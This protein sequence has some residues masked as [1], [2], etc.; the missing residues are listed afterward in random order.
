[1]NYLIPT[2]YQLAVIVIVMSVLSAGYITWTWSPILSQFGSDNAFYLIMAKFLS[3][4]SMSTP[5]IKYLSIHN[6][7]PPFFPLTLAMF[8]GGESIQIAHL[9]TTLYLLVVFLLFMAWMRLEG[10]SYWIA[11]L[12]TCIFALLPGTYMQALDIISENLYLLLSMLAMI[13]VTAAEKQN[14]DRLLYYGAVIIDLAYLTRS[15][16]ITLIAAF[17]LYLSVSKHPG[18]WRYIGVVVLPVVLWQLISEYRG[19]VYSHFFTDFYSTSAFQVFLKQVVFEAGAL[20]DGWKVNINHGFGS[21]F[22][23]GAVA[24]VCCLGL[25]YR[26]YKKKFDAIYL[27]IYFALI[28]VWPYPEEAARF[29]YVVLPITL[30]QGWYILSVLASYVP[31]KRYRDILPV[32]YCLALVITALPDL[33][34]AVQ[35]YN[36]QPAPGFAN[37]KHH[38]DWYASDNNEATKRLVVKRALY[39]D[40]KNVG[41]YVPASGCVFSIKPGLVGLLSG[42]ISIAPPVSKTDDELFVNEVVNSGCRYFYMVYFQSRSFVQPFYPL[43]RMGNRIDVVHVGRVNYEGGVAKYSIIAKLKDVKIG[44]L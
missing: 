6:Q 32:F 7:F 10:M 19:V 37:Y 30:Y 43:E 20:W 18:K 34:I 23:I 36:Q 42:R 29:I 27:F 15:V 31:V 17:I 35:R 38:V 16:G 4:Y 25:G 21:L 5:P 1:M 26:L 9:I 12:I 13:F 14:N 22:V 40:L 24:C 39:E 8:G 44:K 41:K 33:A 28:L 3:P 2:R 11:L